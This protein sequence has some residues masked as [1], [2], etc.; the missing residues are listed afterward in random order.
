MKCVAAIGFLVAFLALPTLAQV[1]IRGLTIAPP[2]RPGNGGIMLKSLLSTR[3]PGEI[4]AFWGDKSGVF[5]RIDK[6]LY[7]LTLRDGELGRE[8]MPSSGFNEVI[9]LT[10]FDLDGNG[11]REFFDFRTSG[12]VNRLV[13]LREQDGKPREVASL[14]GYGKHKLTEFADM[15]RSGKRQIIAV[16]DI[17]NCLHVIGFTND[18]FSH[19]GSLS[20]G[21][22]PIGTLGLSDMDG[23]GREDL[24]VARQPD[25]IEIF[26][27]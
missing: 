7:R 12:T 14:E 24:I 17:N 27:R 21:A 9:L 6:Q 8:P 22:A 25:R 23:D 15:V 16:S 4:S 2:D 3:V 20:C 10:A 18:M 26:L 19:V 1:E 5:A 11:S 13:A